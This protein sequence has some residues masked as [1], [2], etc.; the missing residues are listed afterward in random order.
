MTEV[1]PPRIRIWDYMKP[2]EALKKL[3]EEG[4]IAFENKK[5]LLKQVNKERIFYRRLFWG[6]SLCFL[7]V[8]VAYLV[9]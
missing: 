2:Q 5:N 3:Q 9:K 6:M 7:L 1:T 4:M 8:L